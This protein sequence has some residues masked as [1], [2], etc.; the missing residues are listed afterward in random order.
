MRINWQNDR[1]KGNHIVVVLSSRSFKSDVVEMAVPS[2]ITI[3][4]IASVMTMMTAVASLVVAPCG[5]S[6]SR[7][8]VSKKWN[9]MA[10]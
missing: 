4:S 3:T 9:S 7:G 2:V 1:A 6:P 8:V 5:A 10:R